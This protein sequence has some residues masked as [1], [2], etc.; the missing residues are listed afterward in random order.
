M[1]GMN[2]TTDV[3][4]VGAGLAGLTAATV[5]ARAGRAVTLLEARSEPGGRARSADRAGF[6]MNEGPHALYRT[7]EGIGVLRHLGIEPHGARPPVKGTMAW[8]DGR[9]APFPVGPSSLLRTPLVGARAKLVLGRLLSRLPSLDPA[10]HAGVSI[11]EWVDDAVGDPD[12]GALL[13]TLVRLGTYVNDP[14]HLSADAALT[15]IQREVSDSVLYL[16]GGW[17]TL[18]DQLRAGAVGAG[19]QLVAGRKVDALGRESSRL[20]ASSG[21]EEIAAAAV[22]V[23]GGGPELLAALAGPLSPLARTWSDAARPA[24]VAAL[25]VCLPTGWG[26]APSIVL[27]VDEP[28]YLSVHAP[29]A[30]LAPTGAALV[31]VAK[32]LPSGESRDGEADRRQLERVLDAVRPGWRDDAADTRFLHRVVASTDIP[33]A[34]CGGLAG[35]PGPA[36]PDVPGLFVAG[37]WVGTRGVLADAA[38]SSGAAAGRAAAES[39]T[40]VRTPS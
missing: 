2:H 9:L 5:A 18:V 38:L 19:V 12:G 29:L 1:T 33:K 27:G 28:L 15:Q 26:A 37:D 20:V 34:S 17:Q 14:D 23:A 35:R 39:V 3:L 25:D 7:G 24:R 36:V 13:H 11:G 32:Y 10:A 40:G 4:V 21:A 31:G 16:H 22:V 8:R 6:I 30:R